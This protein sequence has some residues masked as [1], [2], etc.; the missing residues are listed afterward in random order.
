MA[1]IGGILQILQQQQAL[2]IRKEE[3]HEDLAFRLLALETGKVERVQG[4][5]LKRLKLSLISIVI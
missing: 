4:I 5:L 3:R 2:E 1:G